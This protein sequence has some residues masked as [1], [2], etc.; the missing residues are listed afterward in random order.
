MPFPD[1]AELLG[2]LFPLAQAKP[3]ELRQDR[4]VLHHGML[5]NGADMHQ[6]RVT[7]RGMSGQREHGFVQGMHKSVDLAQQQCADPAPA[8]L[9]PHRAATTQERGVL[10]SIRCSR[11][12][13]ADTDGTDHPRSHERHPTSKLPEGIR[14][15]H[16]GLGFGIIQYRIARQKLGCDSA[17]GCMKRRPAFRA[18]RVRVEG[19]NLD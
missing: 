17:P 10:G 19:D 2:R 11:P 5:G 13:E 7:R 3:V 4:A 15:L 14:P 18:G 12:T 6:E 16:L 8:R 1:Q 9:G